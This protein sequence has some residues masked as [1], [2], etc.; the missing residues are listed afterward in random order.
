M[1]KNR[2]Y[3]GARRFIPS[4]IKAIASVNIRYWLLLAGLTGIGMIALFVAPQVQNGAY[5]LR[6]MMNILAG[7][8]VLAIMAVACIVG[9]LVSSTLAML[10]VLYLIAISLGE[11]RAIPARYAR[12]VDDLRP[13]PVQ[14]M[15][16]KESYDFIESDTLK[17]EVSVGSMQFPLSPS[18]ASSGVFGETTST[19]DPIPVL[20]AKLGHTGKL[21][22]EKE[23]NAIDDAIFCSLVFKLH[24]GKTDD[25]ASQ[26]VV[27]IAP[28][29]SVFDDRVITEIASRGTSRYRTMTG[30]DAKMEA[31]GV[32]VRPS[33]A[34]TMRVYA[35]PSLLNHDLLLL[36]APVV[37]KW[38]AIPASNIKSEAVEL[39]RVTSAIYKE[40]EQVGQRARADTRFVTAVRLDK[41]KNRGYD[42]T[43]G[44]RGWH[45]QDVRGNIAAPLFQEEARKF[46]AGIKPKPLEYDPGKLDVTLPGFV[47][48]LTNTAV[49]ALIRRG[50][51]VSITCSICGTG[52]DKIQE[53]AILDEESAR[54]MRRVFRA[55]IFGICQACRDKH[56]I[57]VV[58]DRL[59]KDPAVVHWFLRDHDELGKHPWPFEALAKEL[60][61]LS[62]RAKR[63]LSEHVD[64]L[65][66]GHKIHV[67]KGSGYAFTRG[68]IK[69]SYEGQSRAK[70]CTECGVNEEIKSGSSWGGTRIRIPTDT[71]VLLARIKGSA[72][73]TEMCEACAKKY[74]IEVNGF[75]RVRSG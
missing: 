55:P 71:A 62:D 72:V 57:S 44:G 39:R 9:F 3:T 43:K 63:R 14:G 68:G 51:R 64:Y 18:A 75:E 69:V 12:T 52:P 5:G 30:V 2:K 19:D 37:S 33:L 34:S 59:A 42:A 24:E 4:Q 31:A 8:P 36:P 17:E 73:A 45:E 15:G 13:S 21:L 48:P 6:D 22:T 7:S 66:K 16:D 11:S 41:G 74:V 50:V 25:D 26:L 53:L 10:K 28:A 60:G 35:D 61:A 56:D 27:A 32:G 58:E 20:A 46:E 54:E 40:L 70:P 49:S 23:A 38:Y 1:I 65:E 67:V 47:M 29:G